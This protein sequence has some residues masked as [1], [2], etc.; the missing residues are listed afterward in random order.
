MTKNMMKTIV[1][2]PFLRTN[3]KFK[4]KWKV[5]HGDKVDDEI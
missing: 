1:N 5:A 2:E 4:T 3:I